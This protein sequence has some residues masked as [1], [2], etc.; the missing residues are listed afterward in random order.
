MTS[1]YRIIVSDGNL[2]GLETREGP[3]EGVPRGG[4][5]ID[6]PDPFWTPVFLNFKPVF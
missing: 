5:Y 2:C 6:D 3:Q 1:S 4:Y